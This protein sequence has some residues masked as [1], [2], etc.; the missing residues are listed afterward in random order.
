MRRGVDS[1]GEEDKI[2]IMVEDGN[3]ETRRGHGMGM[4]PWRCS[5][6]AALNPVW[7]A[8]P[9]TAE[10]DHLSCIKPVYID[11]PIL[12]YEQLMH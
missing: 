8:V 11:I 7:R 10:D 3:M 2:K 9:A 5:H 1:V 12:R 6:G 4:P